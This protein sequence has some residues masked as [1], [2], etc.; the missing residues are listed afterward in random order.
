[1]STF[2][3]LKGKKTIV[4]S[5]LQSTFTFFLL[6]YC[7]ILFN[8]KVGRKR[9][10]Q[11]MYAY[12][13]HSLRGKK[14]VLVCLLCVIFHTEQAFNKS[15]KGMEKLLMSFSWCSYSLSTEQYVYNCILCWYNIMGGKRKKNRNI[16]VNRNF[17]SD[18]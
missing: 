1:M 6:L 7:I 16:I 3:N 11:F 5:A 12:I 8:L 10:A 9:P 13:L 2:Q 17:L 4:L 18:N 14:I 15:L